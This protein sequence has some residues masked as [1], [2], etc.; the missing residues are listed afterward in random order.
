MNIEPRNACQVVLHTQHLNFSKTHPSSTS[1]TQVGLLNDDPIWHHTSS[2]TPEEYVDREY[3]TPWTSPT[4][5]SHWLSP[6]LPENKPP[7]T[8]SLRFFYM[9][10]LETPWNLG[11]TPVD[12]H[13]KLSIALTE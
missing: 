10:I 13:D 9:T 3:P 4:S 12:V 5:P 2:L 6:D 7:C 1:T 11:H 8:L